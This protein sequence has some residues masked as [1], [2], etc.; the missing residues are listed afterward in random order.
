M[1]SAEELLLK[2]HEMLYPEGRER[3][4]WTIKMVLELP[5]MVHEWY[6]RRQNKTP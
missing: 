3:P 2:I 4:T 5:A 6:L 1:D